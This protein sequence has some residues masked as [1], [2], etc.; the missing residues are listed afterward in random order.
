MNTDILAYYDGAPNRG[1]L[2]IPLSIVGAA[3]PSCFT[4]SYQRI[5]AFRGL[6]WGAGEA[7]WGNH[8]SNTTCL[9][10]AF[11]TNGEKCGRFW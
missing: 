6:F 8:L 5:A 7:S 1:P 10:H 11:F 4:V 2:K 3:T 9:T